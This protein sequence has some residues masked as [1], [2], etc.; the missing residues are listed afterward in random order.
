[1]NV[2][3]RRELPA[4]LYAETALPGIDTPPLQGEARASVA[5]VGGGFTGLS[6]AL[7]LAEKG[8]DVVVLESHEPGW[9]ASGRNGG[10][11]NPGLKHNPDQIERDFG[12]DLGRRMAGFSGDA[13][14]VVFGLIERHQIVCEAR[15]GGTLR[16]AKAERY[17]GYIRRSAE[18]FARRGDPATLLD[19]GQV[20]AATGTDRYVC[21]MLDRRGGNVNPLGYVRG[22]AR[23][24]Q[25]AGARIH[26]GTP[27]LR[28][29]PQE[30]GWHIGTPEGGVTVEHLV[31][32]MNGYTDAVWPGLQRS[33]VPVHSMIAATE[34]LP[35]TLARAVMPQRS[36]LY[37]HASMTVYY[38]LDQW[39]RLLVGGRSPS[40]ELSDR[41]QFRYLIDYALK[42]WPA[43]KDVRWTHF[44]NGQLAMS[45]DHY[46]HFHEPAPGVLVSLA[47]NGRGV[48]MA[49]AMGTQIAARILGAT[50][51]EL[52][53]PITDLKA[54]PFHGLWRSAV[55]AR[56]AYGRIR[57]TLG[58]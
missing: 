20:A 47:Y 56:V 30:G 10:Q 4:S 45:T 42:L 48:A 55:A 44:W 37:E 38:R 33:I 51:D 39:N 24:A 27:A 57:D 19:R 31:L 32:C 18:A 16:A 52:A 34:P 14:N 36:V 43:L 3:A 35:E 25:Q 50:Q 21:A 22:L 41:A 40:R 11:V 2:F 17:A 9:G 23:A 26:G 28:V 8:V 7:H 1:M 5:V 6:T 29:A 12:P 15:Q 13:P 54:I 53:M 49:T 58:L 46:P